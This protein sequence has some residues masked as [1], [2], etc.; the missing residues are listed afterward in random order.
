M[1]QKTNRT[2]SNNKPIIIVSALIA[3]VAIALVIVLIVSN[4]NNKKTEESGTSDNTNSETAEETPAEKTE[5]QAAEKS[6]EPTEESASSEEKAA[7]PAPEEN[8]SEETADLPESS[9]EPEGVTR[10]GEVFVST[11]KVIIDG[12]NL[13][14]AAEA[15]EAAEGSCHFKLVPSS[16]GGN[17]YETDATVSKGEA[18]STCETSVA[19]SN[20]PAAHYLLTVSANLENNRTGDITTTINLH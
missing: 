19:I 20:L 10:T 9:P 17:T 2:K 3:V 15:A 18:S 12:D 1:E 5:E 11:T 13:I 8:T 6:E 7:E 4:N 16:E 14:L